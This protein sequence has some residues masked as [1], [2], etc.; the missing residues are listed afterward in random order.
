M[1]VP[2]SPVYFAMM[3]FLFWNIKRNPIQEIIGDIVEIN[4]VDIVILAECSIGEIELLRELNRGKSIFSLVAPAIGKTPI[5]VRFPAD[6]LRPLKVTLDLSIHHLENPVTDSKTTI[7]AAHLPSKR[8]YDADA[9]ESIASESREEIES[10]EHEV[11]HTNTIVVGDLNM[12]PFEKG[13][14]SFLGFQ[15][16]MDKR[17]ARS[18]SRVMRGKRRDFFYNPMWSLMGDESSG[19]PG[20]F[21]YNDSSS[22]QNFYWNTLDQVL[23]RPDLIPRFPDNE[24]KIITEINSRSLV[25]DHGIPKSSTVSDHLPLLFKIDI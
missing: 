11:G 5:Y 12:N 7:V 2:L 16:V 13:V 21:Y 6:W 8:H 3:T 18:G 1:L 20:T 10:V 9:L 4:E 23:L 14:A 15:G 24:L 19:P 17:V 22:L 25:S